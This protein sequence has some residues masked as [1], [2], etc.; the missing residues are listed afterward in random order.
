M[1]CP[2][3]FDAKSADA[4]HPKYRSCFFSKIFFR[5]RLCADH[6]LFWNRKFN[7]SWSFNSL[8]LFQ[9]HFTRTPQAVIVFGLCKIILSTPGFNIHSFRTAL[10]F[11]DLFRP[12]LNPY[13]SCH[14]A[15]LC[16][17]NILLVIHSQKS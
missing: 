9:V 5:D 2:K 14:K 17:Y 13:L 12:L 10:T 6:F 7:K 1:I 3:C 4:F 8:E 15:G 16:G 11:L